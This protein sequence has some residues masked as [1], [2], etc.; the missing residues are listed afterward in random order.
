MKEVDFIIGN[1]DKLEIANYLNFSKNKSV[2]SDVF[3]RNKVPDN[4]VTAF[5]NRSRAFVQIQNGCNNKCAFCLARL[6]RGYSVSAPSQ[7][8]IE[9]IKKL[10]ENGYNEIVLTG[11]D[12]S[13]YGAGLDEEI[14]LGLLVQKILKKTDLPRLRISS[15]DIAKL[16]EDLA[17]VYK[18]E[19]RLMPHIHLSLQS[20]D[21]VILTR[22]L[23]RHR[24]EETLEKCHS[25]KKSR[26]D[27][28]FGADM[29]AGFPTETDAM[30]E[31]SLDIVRQ[32]P[33][34][35]GH[36]FPYSARPETKAALMP[37]VNVD[38]RKERA[39]ELRSECERNLNILKKSVNE[40]AQKVLVEEK[41]I[42]RLENYL[43]ARLEEDHEK[44]IGK[45]VEA[46][47]NTR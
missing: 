22:M 34:V 1:N 47:V 40:T 19:K 41:F 12:V 36:I 13:D 42:G 28:I 25:L 2:V 14:N 9:Q 24:R 18:Y 45:I 26:N 46:K 15:I 4:T 29:I 20:G 10:R 37:Q 39:A 5:E 23:R 7:K 6:A 16:N 33:I 8:V 27:I 30:H 43:K 35:F 32:I 11:V 3:E 17:D 44:D 38:K 21:N 31:N